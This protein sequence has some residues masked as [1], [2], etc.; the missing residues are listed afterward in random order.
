MAGVIVATSLVS[1]WNYLRGVQVHAPRAPWK[2]VAAQIRADSFSNGHVL[3]YPEK[4]GGT[5]RFSRMLARYLPGV[6]KF[7][8]SIGSDDGEE[9]ISELIAA[10]PDVPLWAVLHCGFSRTIERRREFI[11]E[12]LGK[13]CKLVRSWNFAQGEHLLKN[14]NLGSFDTRRYYYVLE[15]RQYQ[16]KQ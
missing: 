14:H 6:E 3:L 16:P 15:L 2:E 11:K 5:L 9:K 10:L 1:S 7:L 13:R 12:Q 4:P 8:I